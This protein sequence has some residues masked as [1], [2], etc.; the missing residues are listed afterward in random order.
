MLTQRGRSV[1]ISRAQRGLASFATPTGLAIGAGAAVC[2]SSTFV[3][4]LRKHLWFDELFTYYI[5]RQPELGQVWGVLRTG[6]EP[7]P[8]F[9]YFVTRASVSLFGDGALGIRLPELLGVLLACV[10]LF[11]IVA[12]RST[13]IHG[14]IAM[15]VPLVTQAYLFAPE[16]RPYGLVL[17]FSAAAFLC[18]QL[19]CDDVGGVAAVVGFGVSLMLA[20]ASHYYA[21]F[22]VIPFVIGEVVRYAARR[23]LDVPVLGAFA[24]AIVPL[25]IA[26]PLIRA[27]HELS[28]TFWA[29]PHL[30]SSIEFFGW[31]LRTTAIPPERVSESEA[32]AFVVI[33]VALAIY[34]LLAP[35]RHAPSR[36]RRLRR[37]AAPL[38]I[39]L[40]SLVAAGAALSMRDLTVAVAAGLVVA[41]Y[42]V[43]RLAREIGSV[44]APAP[45]FE[46]AAAAAFA[47]LPLLAVL[48]GS[49]FTGAYVHRYAIAAVIAPA[50]LLPLALH[51]LERARGDA[52]RVAAVVTIGLFAAVFAYDYHEI[53]INRRDERDTIAL[54]RRVQAEHSLPIAVSHPHAAL[55]LSRYAPRSVSANIFALAGPEAALR[56]SGSNS[57]E[58]ALLALDPLAPLRVEPFRAYM[59]SNRPFLLLWT[60][61]F[62]NWLVPALQAEG[63]SLRRLEESR[64]WTLY[65]VSTRKRRTAVPSQADR[66][67]SSSHRSPRGRSAVNGFLLGTGQ[68]ID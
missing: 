3:L 11:G 33:A 36:P 45:A 35:L 25:V 51:R 38:L 42:G 20:T 24:V 7:L 55:E 27:A 43:I 14:L 62:R 9:F 21:V 22:V 31:L 41:A 60:P 44:H 19:R 8:P 56:F 32:T 6:I 54:L 40:G 28:P 68:I 34:L 16:A 57:T 12:R 48:A 37:A 23:R 63:R 66:S 29:K 13:P 2:A 30:V 64:G 67:T 61:Y 26:A 52:S 59:A 39:V 50:V 4:A 5:A 47:L 58:R 49:L 53:S 15:F 46:V 65:L 18:W 10:C 17:G 1:R